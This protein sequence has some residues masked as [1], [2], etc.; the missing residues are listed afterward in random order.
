MLRDAPELL[1]SAALRLGRAAGASSELR[2]TAQGEGGS[3]KPGTMSTSLRPLRWP[4]CTV[5]SAR[6]NSVSSL[7]RPTF[8][9]GWKRVPRWRTMIVPAVTSVPLETLT[10]SRWAVESRPLREEAAPFFFDMCSALRD[11]GDLDRRVLLTVAPPLPVVRLRLVGEAVDLRALGARRRPWPSRWRRRAGPGVASTESPSTSRT[12]RSSTSPSSTPSRSTSSCWPASTLYCLPP[13]AI[14]AYMARE[15]GFPL[16]DPNSPGGTRGALQHRLVDEE[17]A[18]PAD[19]CTSPRTPPRGPRRSASGSSPPGPSSEMSKTW[20][21]VL[22]RARA[23]RNALIT[24]SRF[25]RISMSMKSMTMMPPMSR[26]RSW[27]ATSSAASRLLTGTPSPRGWTSR[28][29][30]RCSRRSTV[31]ASV[32]SMMSE[33]PDGSQTLR[34]SAL[35]SCSCTWKRSKIGQVGSS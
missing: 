18:A 28:R 9:P 34:S 4:N 22:S 23:S 19:R 30:C 17:P 11:R 20:V 27:R 16:V 7:P 8:S 26:S 35:C 14:T 2:L 13:V 33:P 21:R 32:R 10:P 15:T 1:A 31:R 29:S 25:L 6:A 3:S 12:G 5:P 24:S